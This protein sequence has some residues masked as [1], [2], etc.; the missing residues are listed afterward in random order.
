M[1]ADDI[2][3]AVKD[4]GDKKSPKGGDFAGYV[5]RY[6]NVSTVCRL[7]VAEEELLISHLSRRDVPAGRSEFLC[8]AKE[9]AKNQEEKKMDFDGAGCEIGGARARALRLQ[10]K[11]IHQPW[12][13]TLPPKLDFEST[14]SNEC[15]FTCVAHTGLSR[16][17]SITR[18]RQPHSPSGRRPSPAYTT[19]PVHN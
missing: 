14:R 5:Q 8:I 15:T 12:L 6:A 1:T 19:P 11:I 17:P 13:R 16:R 3:W 9:A 10:V 18:L 2:P 7:T 4:E